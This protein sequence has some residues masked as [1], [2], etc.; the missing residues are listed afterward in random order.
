M[1]IKVKNNLNIKTNKKKLKI[2][3]IKENNNKIKIAT[4]YLIN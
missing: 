2:K 1:M 3:M 4:K